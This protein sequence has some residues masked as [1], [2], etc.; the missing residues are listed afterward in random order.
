MAMFEFTVIA[1]GLDPQADDYEE[2][3]WDAGCDDATISFQN[4]R[5]I[6]DFAREAESLQDALDSAIADV[7]KAG[8]R[9]ERIEPDP[10]VSLSD[11]AERAALSRSAMTNYAKG[12]RQSGFPA[13]TAKVSS[14]SPLWDWA[15]IAA[16]LHGHGRL[17]AEAAEAAAVIRAANERLRARE[18]VA[19]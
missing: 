7:R 5:T 2:R 13:P 3:F 8:A 4:G 14:G 6:V 19:A 1:S 16:W 9:I 17:D 12:Y 18:L 10:L 15:E 11:M